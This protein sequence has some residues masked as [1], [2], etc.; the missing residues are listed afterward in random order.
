MGIYSNGDSNHYVRRL[1]PPADESGAWTW[2]NVEDWVPYPLRDALRASDGSLWLVGYDRVVRVEADGSRRTEFLPGEDFSGNEAF[3]IAEDADGTIWL[4]GDAALF[5]YDGRR[6]LPFTIPNEPADQDVSA[7]QQAPD[8]SLWFVAGYGPLIK[9]AN[10]T[11]EEVEYLDT[12]L[13]DL[14]LQGDAVWV[15]S[16]DGLI[17]WENGA[18]RRYTVDDGLSHNEVLSLA[19]DPLIPEWLWVGTM[20]GLNVLNTADGTITTWTR[21]EDTFPG[22]AISML[23]FD[24]QGV[25][26]IGTGYYE[27]WTG[28]GEGAL[29]KMTEREKGKEAVWEI[30]AALGKPLLDDDSWVEAITMDDQ[31]RLWVGTNTRLYLYEADRWRRYTSEDAAPEGPRITSIV[32][33]GD[34]V[35]VGTTDGLY[36]LDSFGWLQLGREGVGNEFITGLYRAA[37]GALWVLTEGGIA[38]LDGDPYAIH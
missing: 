13:Y 18:I 33:V 8:G 37:D 35:W 22:P 27:E 28:P 14:V 32:T 25:L 30:V 10:E 17:R 4:S 7:M 15:A 31:G 21:E 12:Q 19:I 24:T 3:H 34:V 29:V 11:W 38:R 1:I 9:Y 6:W 36:R 23:Y 26:W 2:Q 20:N 5:R 16:R